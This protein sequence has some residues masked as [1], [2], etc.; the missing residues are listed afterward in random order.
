M[1]LGN[2]GY[3]NTATASPATTRQSV[4]S[5]QMVLLEQRAETLSQHVAELEGRL[6]G[7][8][9]PEP[10]TTNKDSPG[11]PHSGVPLGASIAQMNDRISFA[12]M[13]LRNIIDRVEL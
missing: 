1:A 7:V 3:G 9:M 5:E 2:S 13:R 10:P 12:T 6:S 11:T 4:I 8:L